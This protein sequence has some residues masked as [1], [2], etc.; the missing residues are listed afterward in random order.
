MKFVQKVVIILVYFILFLYLIVNY[1]SLGSDIMKGNYLLLLLS[2][3]ICGTI[4]LLT[5]FKKNYYVFEPYTLV[6]LLYI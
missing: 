2:Y 6:S 5:I 1:F 3:L 4:F